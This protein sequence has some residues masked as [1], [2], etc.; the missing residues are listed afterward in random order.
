M[1]LFFEP[2]EVAT[3]ERLSDRQDSRGEE[4]LL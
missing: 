3:G 2:K 1:L 4:S